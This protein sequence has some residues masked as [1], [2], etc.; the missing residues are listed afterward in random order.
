VDSRQVTV[1]APVL[2]R[3][4]AFLIAAAA[5]NA[6]AALYYAPPLLADMAADLGMS[7]ATIGIVTTVTQV[8][9]GLG[10]LLLV[11]LGDL[12]NRRLLVRAQALLSVLALVA[13]AFAPTGPALLAAL[14][15]VGAL[16]VLAQ[17]LIAYAASLAAPGERGR[18]VGIVTSGIVLGILLARTVAGALADLAGWRSVYLTSAAATLVITTLLV[19]ALPRHPARRQGVPYPRLIGSV[20]RL[21]AEVRVLR[22]RAVLALLGFTAFTVLLTPMVLP[23]SAPPFSLSTT[24]IGLFGLSGIAGVLGAARAGRLADHGHAQRATGIGLALMLASWPVIALLPWSLWGLIIGV[25]AFD[26]GLQSVHVANQSLTL[27]ARPE[28]QSRLTAAY[29]VFYS[30]GSATGAITS[31]VVYVSAGWTGVCVLGAAVTSTALLFW[32]LTRREGETR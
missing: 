3:G 29:M 27:R 22:I 15:V 6:V 32:A 21:F 23:L 28:A 13:V 11:P 5:G 17:V 25:L 16:A 19:R 18:I 24:E 1:A 12:L 30:I 4:T 31:T 14:V 8:G 9:Y 20:F 2:P 7:R 26:F 10:L